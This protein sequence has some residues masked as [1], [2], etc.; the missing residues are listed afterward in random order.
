MDGFW[1]DAWRVFETANR[2]GNQG[3]SDLG[4]LIDHSGALRI[5][6]SEGWHPEALRLHYGVRTVYQVSRTPDG[7]RVEGSRPGLTCRIDKQNPGTKNNNY[8]AESWRDGPSPSRSKPL[9]T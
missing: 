4:I 8:N 3:A 2:S 7:V 6:S 5:V 1:T 9:C